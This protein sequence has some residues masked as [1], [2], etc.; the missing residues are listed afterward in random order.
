VGSCAA[1]VADA[2]VMLTA[3]RTVCAIGFFTGLTP[4]ELLNS[5]ICIL[6]NLNTNA[7]DSY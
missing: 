5:M 7:N 2:I 1:V 4:A 6:N 3:S